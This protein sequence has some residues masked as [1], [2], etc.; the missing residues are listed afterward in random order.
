M[1]YTYQF[2][3]KCNDCVEDIW[4]GIQHEKL[5]TKTKAEAMG[6]DSETSW[7]PYEDSSCKCASPQHLYGTV[8]LI[9]VVYPARLKEVER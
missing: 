8:A 7:M 2:K 9:G 5:P 1:E 4:T 6:E 3:A